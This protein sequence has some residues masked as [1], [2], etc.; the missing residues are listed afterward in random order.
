MFKKFDL[1]IA[2]A[3][4]F[5][6]TLSTVVLKSIA[7]NIFPTYFI[8][9]A[10][11]IVSFIVFSQ[12]EFDVLSLFSSHFYIVSIVLLV[13]TLIIGG[14]TRGVIRW[15]PIGSI[16]I[17]PSE[18]V[19]PFLLIFFANFLTAERLDFKRLVHVLLLMALPLFL[20][21]VQPSLGVTVL[22]SVG[23]L[24]I[25]LAS[26]I[27]KKHFLYLLLVSSILIPG[28]FFILAP[29]QKSRISAFL[30]PAS[31]PLGKGYNSI[32]S[33]ISVGSGKLF[34]RGLGKGIQTQLAF[35]PERHTDFIFASISEEMGFVGASLV[36]LG[37][38][39]VLFRLAVLTE[40][41]SGSSARAYLSGLFLI[42]FVQVGI[43]IGMN[44]GLLP[45][46]GIPFPLLSAGGSS[47]LGTMIGLGIA[48]GTKKRYNIQSQ[49]T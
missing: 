34:G 16:S 28:I 21:L 26:E 24:G 30:N 25:F 17:Q 39:V 19:R 10:L 40:H 3:L 35:L 11:G 29:Y 9:I 36:L 31:D 15:I 47:L 6:T 12:I 1:P 32:Q 42:L 5:L 4:I 22:T 38:F 13:A 2:L 48:N 23:F 43:H 49:Q 20:I 14:V 41:S 7:P 27:E 45:I 44:M 37:L 46:T 33:Q 18:I 8:Y